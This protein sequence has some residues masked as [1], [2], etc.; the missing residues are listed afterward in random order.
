MRNPVLD[1][2]QPHSM[3]VTPRRVWRAGTADSIHVLD[4]IRAT[5]ERPGQL[6]PILASSAI[7]DIVDRGRC[8]ALMV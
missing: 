4:Q 7:N 6:V 8:Q 2:P 1:V 5:V 3:P